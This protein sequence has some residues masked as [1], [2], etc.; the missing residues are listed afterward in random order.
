MGLINFINKCFIKWLTIER[1]S[2]K[3][4][5]CD[6][7]RIRY[8]LRPCD[9]ILIEGRSRVSEV[10]KIITQ[11]SWSHSSLYIGRIH[12]IEDPKAREHA[13]KYFDGSPNTQLLIEGVMGKGTVLSPLTTYKKDHIRIC[14]P[15]GL[16]PSDAQNIIN[17]SLKE[18]GKDY[19]VQQILDLARFLFPWNIMPRRWRSKL[20]SKK[21][22]SSTRTVCSTMLAAAFSSVDFPILPYVKTHDKK[23][24]EL[25]QRNPRLFTPSDFDYSPYFEII[26]YPF[27]SF[28][29]HAMYRKLPWN[30]DGLVSNDHEQISS[31]NPRQDITRQELTDKPKWE[32]PDYEITD[33]S[34]TVDSNLEN[35]TPQSDSA[36]EIWQ[37]PETEIILNSNAQNKSDQNTKTSK[38]YFSFFMFGENGSK[39]K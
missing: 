36:K 27:I 1:T 28:D 9:V 22:G 14:R 24:I 4:P 7:E 30:R 23:G 15:R 8:E 6:F 17:Y 21:I 29:N 13:S 11:S 32:K 5:M 19:D 3:F 31:V 38:K 20:F 26:K 37:K 35:T 18:L 2:A 25:I 33:N 10:I 12:D 16:S 39:K 34:K